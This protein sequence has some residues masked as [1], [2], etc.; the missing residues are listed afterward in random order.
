MRDFGNGGARSYNLAPGRL[1]ESPI[2]DAPTREPLALV[3]EPESE[4]AST[5]EAL[6]VQRG[7]RVQRISSTGEASVVF[8]QEAPALSF[9]GIDIATDKSLKAIASLHDLAPGT[10][11]LVISERT[12]PQ[13]IRLALSYGASNVI[14]RPLDSHEVGFVLDRFYRFAQARTT[15]AAAFAIGGK[16]ATELSFRARP[17]L[18]SHV[19]AFLTEELQEHFPEQQ[20]PVADVKLALYEAFANAMEHG[21]LGISFEEK[22]AAMGTPDGIRT[23]IEGRLEDPDLARRRVF[24]RVEYDPDTV[25]YI[26]RDEGSGFD[27]PRRLSLPMAETT[28]LHGR[29][30]KMIE[31]YMDDVS[32]NDAG[33]ELRMD[34]RV[35]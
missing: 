11:L 33:N 17:G 30:L 18:L 2:N 32:W 7:Y 6:A 28:A 8:G 14:Q 3:I 25:G 19:I 35:T 24:V 13:A 29:G 21:N 23:L 9:L 31:F 34:K 20:G 15:G 4:T 1:E 16:R 10:P 26:I 5:L 27:V 22:T 12:D